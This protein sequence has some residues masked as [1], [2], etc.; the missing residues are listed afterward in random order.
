MNLSGQL[1]IRIAVNVNRILSG[2][3]G[4]RAEANQTINIPACYP[5][6]QRKRGITRFSGGAARNVKFII[7]SPFRGCKMA[8]DFEKM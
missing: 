1:S 5:A 3:C 6:K 7:K 2:G 4:K 8:I